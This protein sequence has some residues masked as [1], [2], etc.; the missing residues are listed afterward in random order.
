LGVLTAL[1]AALVGIAAVLAYAGRKHL[2]QRQA[3]RALLREL[4]AEL[5]TAHDLQMGLM[6][7][8]AP[9]V[10]G[11]SLAGRCLTANHVGGDFFQYFSLPGAR[12]AICLTDVTGH[13][14]DAAIPAVMFDGILDSQIRL[15]GELQV[16]FR[17][18]NRVLCEKLSRRTHVAFAMAEI[19]LTARSARLANAGCPYPCHFQRTTGEAIE[20][21]VEAYPFGVRP[22]TAYRQL[23]VRLEAG[24]YLVFYSDGLAEAANAAGD[25]FTFEGTVAAIRAA[26]AQGLSPEAVIDHLLTAVRAFTGDLPQADDMTCVVIK[27]EE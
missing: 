14:M 12:L 10:A 17:R 21:A 1:A 5:Q 25:L 6:P 3:E 11:L 7:K 18:L 20:V 23:D 27:V 9:S 16:L 2:G 13:A 4:E 8:E 15:G 22:D 26:C 24:D 19:D